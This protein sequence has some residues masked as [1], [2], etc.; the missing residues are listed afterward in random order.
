[1][2]R[3]VK[4]NDQAY[5]DKPPRPAHCSHIFVSRSRSTSR[6]RVVHA[7]RWRLSSEGN[8]FV[9]KSLWKSPPKA[10][11]RGVERR[12][13]KSVV[14]KKI[15]KILKNKYLAKSFERSPSSSILFLPPSSTAPLPMLCSSRVATTPSAGVL[16]QTPTTRSTRS[17]A[18]VRDTRGRRRPTVARMTAM[19]GH[20]H[21][22]AIDSPLMLASSAL[23]AI[24]T[25]FA[26]FAMASS[27][28]TTALVRTGGAYPS[29]VSAEGVEI[30]DTG[31]Q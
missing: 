8:I 25:G 12:R 16:R 23:S 5:G 7:A 13:K 24:G 28:E 21:L 31:I 4:Q 1:V 26:V 29:A 14:Y 27:A 17:L 10:L 18:F 2:Y 11:A 19:K 15:N 9:W 3:K 20:D 22:N 30:L 6:R